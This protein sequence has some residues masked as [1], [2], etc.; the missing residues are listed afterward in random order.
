MASCNQGVCTMGACLPDFYDRDPAVPGCETPCTKTNGGVEICDGLDNDCDGIVDDNLGAPTLTCKSKGV[1][2]GVAPT[3]AGSAG[4]ACNYPTSYQSVEDSAKGCDG[5][6]NDCDGTVDEAF[7][8][9]KTCTVGS[10]ACA[11]TGTWVCD[12]TATGGRRCNGSMK[13]PGVEIC[14]GQD[15]DCDGKIDEL[16]S[17]SD[18]TADDKIVY[19]PGKNVTMFVYEA[20]RYDASGTSHGFDSTRR[21]CAVAGRQPWSNVTKEEAE[22]ACEK[23]GSGWRLC[24]ATEWA[25]ACNGS[26][27]TTFPYGNAYD[28]AKCN[29]Y[30]YPKSSGTTTLPTGAA[31]FCISDLSAAAG[32]EL[33]DMSGNVKEWTLSTTATTGPYEMRGGA[34]DIASFIDSSVTPSVM[35]APGLQCDASTPAPT[36]PVRLPSVGFRCCK[37]GMLAP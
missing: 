24:T 37:T 16:D 13:P 34:Y 31:S 8:I 17:M 6:D 2:A 21:P 28:G 25:D 36:D 11:G 12:S 7:S 29:G 35:R 1:C 30:D 18:R 20:S 32:D 27:N 15:D 19:F 4:W 9:G 3:C 22:A 5:L 14:N 10:G 33:Y 26:S 23:V